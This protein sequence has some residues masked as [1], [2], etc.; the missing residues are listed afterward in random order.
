MKEYPEIPNIEKHVEETRANYIRIRDEKNNAIR[1]KTL[2]YFKDS[3]IQLEMAKK[4]G[5]NSCSLKCDD[6]DVVNELIK[7]YSEEK[8]EIKYV[9]QSVIISWPE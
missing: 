7:K 3:I 5:S 9:N 4:H 6:V 2:P 8:Y 1:N